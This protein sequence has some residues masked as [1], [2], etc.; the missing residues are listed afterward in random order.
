MT[1]FLLVGLGLIV[2]SVALLAQAV[3]LPRRRAAATIG[4]IGAYGFGARPVDTSSRRSIVDVVADLVGTFV[5]SRFGRD[6]EEA[7]RNHLLAAGFYRTGPKKFVGY[8]VITTAFVPL[9]WLWVASTA[10]MGG[11]V[12]VV[13]FLFAVVA[14]WLGPMQVVKSRSQRRLDAIDYE[15]PELIDLLIVTVEAGL[16]FA[17]SLQ[18]AAT[19]VGGALGDELRLVLQEQSMGLST[20]ETLRNMLARCDTP[21]VRSFVRAIVQGE[22]LGVSIGQILRNISDEMRSRRRAKAEERAQKAPI[23]ILFPLIFLI[24]PAMFLILLG[25]AIFH[26]IDAF[27]G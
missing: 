14:G 7:L 12:I 26:F 27:H 13:G 10:G 16:G 20:E 9:G 6:R 25:P 11:G 19:R 23:K 21:F 15:L 3:V 5:T 2:A 18:V 24:F 1:L 22:T 17:S 4:H 8:R